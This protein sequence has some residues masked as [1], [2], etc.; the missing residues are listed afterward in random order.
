[1]S[2]LEYF[3]NLPHLV[4][5]THEGFFGG[6]PTKNVIIHNNLGGDCYCVGGG[7]RSKSCLKKLE[8]KMSIAFLQKTGLSKLWDLES[9][10]ITTHTHIQNGTIPNTRIT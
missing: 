10:L 4:T 5:V 9:H 7:G 8:Q 6:L 1:M 2:C 3:L